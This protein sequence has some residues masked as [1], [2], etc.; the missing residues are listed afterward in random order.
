MIDYMHWRKFDWSFNSICV[1]CFAT[2]ANAEDEA[3]LAEHELN[4]ICVDRSFAGRS[5]QAS[6]W[7]S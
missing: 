3:D 1:R 4:H 5:V 2:I 7:E 6:S